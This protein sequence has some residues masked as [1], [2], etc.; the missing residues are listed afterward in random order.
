MIRHVCPGR[1]LA[2]HDMKIFGALIVGRYSKI[3]ILEREKTKLMLQN[4]LGTTPPSP[5]I[6]TS[7]PG[8]QL[9]PA[10]FA[11]AL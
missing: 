5:L 11:I 6:L 2:V 8:V 9:S 3:E 7:R 4:R 10:A 1:F